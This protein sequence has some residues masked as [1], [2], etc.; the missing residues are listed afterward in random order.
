M[1]MTNTNNNTTL[2]YSSA[3]DPVASMEQ[4]A[5]STPVYTRTISPLNLYDGSELRVEPVQI[6]DI[7]LKL[8]NGSIVAASQLDLSSL[9]TYCQQDEVSTLAKKLAE[10]IAGINPPLTFSDGTTQ[11][12]L[13]LF[14][15]VG[16][17]GFIGNLLTVL[18]ILRT[19]SLHSQTNYFLASLAVSDLLLILVGVPFDLFFLW[20]RKSIVLLFQG[21]CETA[22]TL[23][24]W[25]TFNSILTIVSL[26]GE[27]LVAICYPFSLR[28]LFHRN[29]VIWLIIILWIISFFPSI[30]MGLQFKLVIQDF[31]GRTHKHPNGMGRKCDFIGWGESLNSTD[32]YTFEIML[33]VT[34][35]LPVLFIIYCYMRILRTLNEATCSFSST[36]TARG[37]IVNSFRS[38]S[39]QHVLLPVG[40]PE[41]NSPSPDYNGE[42]VFFKNF[43]HRKSSE[44]QLQLSRDSFVK[45]SHRSQQAHKTVMMML[46][47]IAA[48]FFTCYFP[49]HVERLIVK[50]GLQGCAQPQACLLLYHGT[51]LLQYIGA[52]L[53]PIIYNVMSRRFRREFQKI[54]STIIKKEHTQ[55]IKF[56]ENQVLQMTPLNRLL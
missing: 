41:S 8:S 4:H 33:F 18:I 38:S 11:F 20:R 44:Q 37:N 55:E 47:M 25:F 28:P 45:N 9:R 34:F 6:S 29:A 3:F 16:I 35:M 22:S 32:H 5:L 36:S 14:L 7:Q 23:I 56:R 15:F 42:R 1:Q 46:I 21:F 40:M 10:Y 24:G 39:R 12:L 51:G 19:P 49:Y 30:Y 26:T 13:I 53:N 52:A 43:K 17:I 31:C 2:A 50:Y 48:L 54:F 27:R